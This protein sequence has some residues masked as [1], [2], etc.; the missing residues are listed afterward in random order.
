MTERMPLALDGD[1]NLFGNWHL[2]L[3]TR[4][5]DIPIGE[6][7]GAELNVS[8]QKRALE[9]MV[10]TTYEVVR[11]RVSKAEAT[12]TGNV[13]EPW[14]PDFV[15]LFGAG[16]AL[17][18]LPR[19]TIGAVTYNLPRLGKDEL[20]LNGTQGMIPAL[21]A[22]PTVSFTSA[23]DGGIAASGGISSGT[24]HLRAVP[25]WYNPNP[26]YTTAFALG[27]GARG[28]DYLYGVPSAA[29]SVT[30]AAN[31]SCVT[32]A[33][34]ALAAG[35]AN[36]AE[37]LTTADL[38]PDAVVILAGATD[39]LADAK[40]AAV[41]P[42]VDGAIPST[43]SIL[44]FG[45]VAFG[46][47]TALTDRGRVEVVTVAAGAEVYTAK[48]PGTDYNLDPVTG[49]LT[50]P[51]GSS[52]GKYARLR[53]TAWCVRNPAITQVEGAPVISEDVIGLRLRN[54]GTEE[55]SATDKAVQGA[56]VYCPRFNRATL[57]A[58]LLRAAQED[59]AKNQALEL[60]L[61]RDATIGGFAKITVYSGKL[62]D[63]WQPLELAA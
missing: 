4:A 55:S 51:A 37:P 56:E 3:V 6:F 58:R 57:G 11:E 46:A 63:F 32:L 8:V 26:E 23:G 42:V 19:K 24:Y 44:S 22:L 31:S 1:G 27:A 50:F 35:V 49:E 15:G 13:Y 45:T 38:V 33:G 48:T 2:S 16:R 61:L 21:P 10:D 36:Y 52:I 59:F 29:T 30:V 54:L 18:T 5:G 62:C 40:V 9:H 14:H 25:V 7:D 47:A 12:L 34:L 39:A 28:W 17:G 20:K 43:A 41:I 53:V 60:A